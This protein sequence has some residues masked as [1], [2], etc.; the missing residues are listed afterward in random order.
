MKEETVVWGIHAGRGGE[1]HSLFTKGCTLALGWS[2]VGNLSQI[3]ASRDALKAKVAL[4]FPEAKSG[5]VT[6]YAGAR[7]APPASPAAPASCRCRR[8]VLDTRSLS[9]PK[10]GHGG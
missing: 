5:A 3:L 10:P 6:N 2:T 7:W 4:A 9:A 8:S 1:A